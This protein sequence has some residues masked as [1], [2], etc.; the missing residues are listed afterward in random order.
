VVPG[1]G[2]LDVVIPS[3]A[4]SLTTVHAE[5]RAMKAQITALL[6]AHPLSPVLTSMPGVGLRTAAVL[7]VTVGDGTSFPT[8]AHLASY[9]GLAP[10]H[11]VVGHLVPR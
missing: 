7:L 2:T 9:A 10:H 8:A 6:E 1:A 5:R 3:L 4:A 11:E